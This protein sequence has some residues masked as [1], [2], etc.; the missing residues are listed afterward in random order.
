MY[1]LS[2]FITVSHDCHI[3][4][5]DRTDTCFFCRIHNFTHQGNILIVNNGVNGQ[6]TL[7]SMFITYFGDFTQ[8]V[9][10]K[11]A[12]RTRTHVQAFNTEIDGIGSG[13]K[14]SRQ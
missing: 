12:R 2:Y 14:G 10:S 8:I 3:G 9:Y 5:N 11:S 6:V 13:M 1:L 4:R 7:Y